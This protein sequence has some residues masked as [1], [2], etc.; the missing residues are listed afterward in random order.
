M[1]ICG[2]IKESKLGRGGNSEFV[3]D[4][5]KEKRM[6]CMPGVPSAEVRIKPE[7]QAPK[8]EMK[9]LQT[10]FVIGAGSP[11]NKDIEFA[12]NTIR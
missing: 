7:P 10:D 11:L 8:M 6:V 1:S 2:I 9:E 4:V 12:K 3:Q 5:G